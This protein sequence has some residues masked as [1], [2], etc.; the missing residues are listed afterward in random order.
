MSDTPCPE[1]GTA[2]PDFA[3]PD[4][5]GRLSRLSDFAGQAQAVLAALTPLRAGG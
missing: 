2:A 4:A 1:A 3:L 5:E